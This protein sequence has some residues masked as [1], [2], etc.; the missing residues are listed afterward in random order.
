MSLQPSCG[1]ALYGVHFVMITDG[2]PTHEKMNVLRR[3][4]HQPQGSEKGLH[5][6]APGS[7]GRPRERETHAPALSWGLHGKGAGEQTEGCE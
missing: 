2:K 6:E 1:H 7:G 3:G 5:G 4:V